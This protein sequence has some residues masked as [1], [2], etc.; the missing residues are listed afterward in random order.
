MEASTTVRKMMQGNTIS[1]PAYQR[2][3]SWE[4]PREQSYRKTHTDVFISDLDEYIR[5]NTSSPYYFGH[6]LFEEKGQ[7]LFHVIDGQQ[8]L[9]TIVMFFS[10]LFS[11]LQL[12]RIL[13]IAE[14][15][16]F[17]DVVIR[18]GEVRF[19]TVDYDNQFFMDYVIEP[20]QGAKFE[21]HTVSACRIAYAF[22]SFVKHFADRDEQYLTKMLDIISNASCSTHIVKNES[23]A[24]QMFIFQNNRGQKPSNL[25]IVKAQ[26]M[27]NVLLYGGEDSKWVLKQVTNRFE[28]IYK[29]IS[30]IEYKI[31]EDAVLVYT[32]RVYFNR[33]GESSALEIINKKLS[34]PDSVSFIKDF[35]LALATNFEILK[36]F[37]GTDER[38]NHAIHS[39][40]TL[41][42]IHVAYPFIIKAYRFGLDTKTV[43]KLCSALESLVLR[44]RLI[45]TRADVTTRLTNSPDVFLEFTETNKSIQPIIERVNMIKGASAG[46]W[47]YWNNSELEKAIQGE[48]DSSVAKFLL[49]KY[50]NFLESH[51][52]RYDGYSLTRYDK[53]HA[54]ELEHIAPKNEP[55][56]PNN[57]DVQNRGKFTTGYDEYDEEFVSQY[58][59]CLGNYLLISKEINRSIGNIPFAEKRETYTVLAQQKEIQDLVPENG[60]W[61][62]SVI[63]KRKEKI[64]QFIKDNF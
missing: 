27:H 15:H 40:V 13:S 49:W 23:E 9:T 47:G 53:I 56:Q 6:F 1:V 43:E 64:I 63:R 12:L 41:G 33:L 16:C 31:D 54:P 24:V 14:K 22:D 60:T 29:A 57:Y 52:N 7:D 39:L 59:D 32:V 36:K 58:L 8:R 26:F 10:A 21:M 61:D 17:E 25:E 4:T 2:A 19:S 42:G 35:S 28:T 38:E 55:R 30:S 48:L 37:L 3:Y 18:D 45:G 20:T 62:K 46:W 44:Q 5:G 11:K 34:E 50:E 51:E